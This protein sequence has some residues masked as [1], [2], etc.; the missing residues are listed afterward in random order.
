[1]VL[2]AK[3]RRLPMKIMLGEALLRRLSPYHKNR[4]E[5]EK[6]L[7][8]H[9]AGFKGEKD[10]DYFLTFLPQHDY[11]IYR[12]LRL[13]NNRHAFQ[14][15]TLVLSPDFA[16]II[17]CKNLKGPLYY[18]HDTGQLTRTTG[19][20]AE[21]LPDPFSQVRRQ[22]I[23]L[24]RWMHQHRIQCPPIET[25]VALTNSSTILKTSKQSENIF[26]SIVHAEQITYQ[27]DHLHKMNVQP[28]L[29][30]T[31]MEHTHQ[32]LLN[33]HTDPFVNFSDM[34]H[35]SKEDLMIGVQCPSCSRY[36]M[37]RRKGFWRCPSCQCRDSSAH[38]Q[39]LQDYFLLY[40]YSITNRA[41]RDYLNVTSRKI[42]RDILSS[43]GLCYKGTGRG[44]I[45]FPPK[46]APLFDSP[47]SQIY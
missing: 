36:H 40:D 23:Q 21:L 3:E 45:Y 13:I 34:Y 20:Y 16:L 5:I 44:R 4:Q 17:E 39:A 29:S 25:M 19:A 1:M 18:N 11:H 42:A 8:K 33:N 43:M 35:V 12:D 38:L 2:L 9:W 46:N 14:I 22:Q 26:K 6:S 27:I 15:D 32:L 24:Y 28:I 30:S 47:K 7:A 37:E 10:L 41:C 31:K